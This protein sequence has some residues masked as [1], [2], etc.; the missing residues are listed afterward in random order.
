MLIFNSSRHVH[1][2]VHKVTA[3]GSRS[4]DKAQDF[5]QTAAGGDAS[6]KAYGSYGDVFT[7]QVFCLGPG[8]EYY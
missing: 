7:D 8:P 1:D 6:I 4:T 2:V 3:V 5:I